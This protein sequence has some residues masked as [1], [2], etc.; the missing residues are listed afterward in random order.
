MKKIFMAAIFAAASFNAFGAACANGSILDQFNAGSCEINGWSLDSWSLGQVT[1][2]GYT[3]NA[4]AADILV[5][6]NSF[7]LG[8]GTQG[9]SVSFSN[10]G[11][12]DNG[13]FTANPGQ[14]NQSQNWNTNFS[15]NGAP[16]G[17]ITLGTSGANVTSGNGQVSIQKIVY[18]PLNPL[19]SLGSNN[20]LSVQ[21]FTSTNPTN[22]YSNQNNTLTRISV[23]DNYQIGRAH[24]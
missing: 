4:T 1:S 3:N 20:I 13:Y 21:G 12:T 5:S 22:V 9:F 15:V 8:N 24:V 23:A 2:V 10:N 19:P 17:L 6:F 16:V 11:L 14:P 18:D 7:T